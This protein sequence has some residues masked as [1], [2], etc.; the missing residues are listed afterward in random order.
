MVGTGLQKLARNNG[1]AV[2]SGVA[3]GDLR[4]FATTF[5]E[6]AG[7]KR[8]DIVTAFPTLE[9][10]GAFLNAIEAVQVDKVYRVQTIS[11][12]AWGLCVVFR[13]TIGTMKRIEAFIDWFYPLLKTYDAQKATVC[14]RCGCDAAGEGWYLI[15][16]V[17]YRLHETC[18]QHEQSALESQQQQRREE[19]TG[20]Y[21]LGL[22][23]AV[24]GAALGGVVWAVVLMLGYMASLV[25]LLIGWL[26]EKGYTL[27]KGKQGKGK[28]VILILAI[29]FGVLLG[30]VAAD[31]ITLAKMMDNG[32]LPGFVY[33]DIPNIILT[34]LTG[35]G[36][37]RGATIKNIVMGLVFAALGVF[38]LLRKAGKEVAD[39][40]FKKLR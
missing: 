10:K 19:D 7:F 2:D 16:G 3:Y 15:N 1:M 26:S 32:E 40:Q 8:I 24:G 29:I 13:D 21:V 20:S 4:G 27:L 5:S 25:G 34:L 9:S 35:D 30:T 38:A 22:V 33:G 31:G 17:A 37:Y 14:A 39:I 36:E 18:A 23:G 28:I 6:G 12:T 11:I